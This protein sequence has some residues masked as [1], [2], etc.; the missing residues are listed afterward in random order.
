MSVKLKMVLSNEK[1][2]MLKQSDA[3]NVFKT[4]MFYP[5]QHDECDFEVFH[6]N[7]RDEIQ[8]FIVNEVWK[9]GPLRHH[10]SR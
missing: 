3:L 6:R 2:K 1:C 10:T 5:D 7:L 9:K 8:E 4:L